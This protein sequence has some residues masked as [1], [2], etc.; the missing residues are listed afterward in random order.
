MRKSFSNYCALPFVHI[1][2]EGNGDIKGCC[3]SDTFVD[4]DGELFN[5][6]KHRL[7]DL[8]HTKDYQNFRRSFL[9]NRQS[10]KCKTCW[11]KEA[12]GVSSLRQTFTHRFGYLDDESADIIPKFIEIKMGN[13]CNLMCAICHPENSTKWVNEILR[14][15][16]ASDVAQ[17]NERAKFVTREK[18]WDNDIILQA[19]EFHLMGGEPFAIRQIEEFIDH[20]LDKGNPSE[21]KI[22]FNTNG[23]IFP[24]KLIHKLNYFNE[25]AISISVD[26]IYERME[27]QRYNANFKRVLDN[28][29]LFGQLDTKTFLTSIDV[30]W[31][32]WNAF[33]FKEISHFYEDVHKRLLC[34]NPYRMQETRHSYSG[35]IYALNNLHPDEKVLYQAA[36]ED[37]YSSCHNGYRPLLDELLSWLNSPHEL[38]YWNDRKI[39]ISHLDQ[40]REKKFWHVFPELETFMNQ[41]SFSDSLHS[42][43]PSLA[44]S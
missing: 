44:N 6:N 32:F 22:W 3:V 9:E 12:Q 14:R 25:V 20:L 43:D 7:E 36:L 39:E 8:L 31:S 33:Y 17:A 37:A 40:T 16:P 34:Q 24:K 1:A 27:Y 38:E 29:K 15:E 13:Q 30:C 11:Q 10:S 18:I 5:L 21:V 35:N 19:R 26:D 2:V 23:T 42:V 4:D 41:K 28:I